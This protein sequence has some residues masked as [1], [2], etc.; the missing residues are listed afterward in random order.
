[1]YSVEKIPSDDITVKCCTI[2]FA[3]E[4]LLQLNSILMV[5]REF[6]T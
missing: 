4:L 5:R 1:M 3:S 6:F 2:Y